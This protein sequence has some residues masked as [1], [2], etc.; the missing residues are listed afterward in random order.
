M[1]VLCKKT[2]KYDHKSLWIMDGLYYEYE[3]QLNREGIDVH[4]MIY[5]P[6]PSSSKKD[7]YS[8]PQ[9]VFEEYFETISDTRN[10]RLQEI[11]I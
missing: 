7:F 4:Y 9:F 5:Y 3:V 10:R 11:G 1:I 6:Y 2:L 8:V